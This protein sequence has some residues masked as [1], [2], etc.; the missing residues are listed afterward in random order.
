MMI[1]IFFC[2]GIN[3]WN[4]NDVGNLQNKR[5]CRAN[6]DNVKQKA[7]TKLTA[8]KAWWRPIEYRSNQWR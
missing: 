8:E 1:I 7:Q 4:F 2:K 5:E 6:E 3:F